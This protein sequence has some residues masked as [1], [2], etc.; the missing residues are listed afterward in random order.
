MAGL[1]AIFIPVYAFLSLPIVSALRG[2]ATK[3]LIRVAETRGG[4]VGHI[5][6]DGRPTGRSL[7]VLLRATNR[8]DKNRSGP[9]TQNMGRARLRRGVGHDHRR[10][11]H[12]DHQVIPPFLRGASVEFTQPFSVSWRV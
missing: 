7:G 11:A 10:I 4:P 6:R 8:S 12:L 2:N 9:V 5:S 1:Y 3:F